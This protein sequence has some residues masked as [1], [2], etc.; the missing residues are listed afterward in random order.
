MARGNQKQ[1]SKAIKAVPELTPVEPPKASPT[2]EQFSPVTA[3][4]DF[5]HDSKVVPARHILGKP[6]GFSKFEAEIE[7]QKFESG[8]IFDQKGN[9]LMSITQGSTNSV[10]WEVTD[11][12]LS[13]KDGPGKAILTHNHPSGSSFSGADFI[14]C[15]Q[16]RF[17]E[18]RAVGH[19][20]VYSMLGNDK[21]FKKYDFDFSQHQ[22]NNRFPRDVAVKM[23]NTQKRMER[24]INAA[25]K[26]PE[27]ATEYNNWL[28]DEILR[29]G[30]VP[31]DRKREEYSHIQNVVVAKKLGLTYIR[32]PIKTD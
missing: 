7:K 26:D 29:V 15:A 23:N 22:G 21:F 1:S 18:E 30:D 14:A 28:D 11:L 3:T 32:T 8:A 10:A 19:H 12:I 13:Q 16:G 9:M 31:D 4:A 17:G 20:F 25:K 24:D 5:D 6:V 2:K 27:I